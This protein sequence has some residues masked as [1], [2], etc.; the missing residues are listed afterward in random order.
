VLLLREPFDRGW[1][2]TVDGR[3]VPILRADYFLQ[4]VSV[5]AGSS[6]VRFTYDD[7]RIGEGLLASGVVWLLLLFAIGITATRER[8]RERG[9]LSSRSTRADEPRATVE[10]SATPD[11]A[12]GS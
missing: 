6:E 8:R 9:A 7:P 1:H 4:A 3:P 5:P 12:R 11:P 10:T 2:A